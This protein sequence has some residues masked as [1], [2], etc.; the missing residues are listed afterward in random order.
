[1]MG[2]AYRDQLFENQILP[3]GNWA[4]ELVVR[5]IA[6]QQKKGGSDDEFDPGCEPERA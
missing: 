1:M 3:C 5:G 4:F 2:R 6:T